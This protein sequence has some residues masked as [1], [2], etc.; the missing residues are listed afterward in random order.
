MVDEFPWL[1]KF[2]R[3]VLCERL[4]AEG[5][6]RI[7][8]AVEKIHAKFLRERECVVRTLARDEL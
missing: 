5:L 1:P 7:V 2:P 4:H 3:D 6:R 8:A